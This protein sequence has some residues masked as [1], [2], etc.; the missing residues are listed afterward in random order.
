MSEPNNVRDLYIQVWNE[1]DDAERFDLVSQY[2]SS[3]ATYI[4]PMMSGEGHAGVTDMIAKARQSF[5]GHSFS[6][7]GDVDA[8]GNYVRFSWIL[9]A[10][11]PPVALGT[12]VVELDSEGRIL[13]VIGF[14]DKA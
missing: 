12:D 10:D 2:W 1:K 7:R 4:D 8:F 14:L 11:G 9:A 6:P 3:D 13:R 5:P